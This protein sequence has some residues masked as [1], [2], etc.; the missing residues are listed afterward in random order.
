MEQD[1]RYPIGKFSAPASLSEADRAKLIED[2]AAAPARLAPP[3]PACQPS[4][5][6]R[7]IAKAAGPSA[8]SPITS[9]TA[10]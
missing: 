2:V 10:T 7:P 8:S 5:F 1:P 3:S 4:N 6:P 9:P